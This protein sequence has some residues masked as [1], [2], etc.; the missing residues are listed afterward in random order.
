MRK[1]DIKTKIVR[2]LP[3]FIIYI[4]ILGLFSIN[5]YY[6]NTYPEYFISNPKS[7]YEGVPYI[8]SCS[9]TFNY[10]QSNNIVKIDND[11][12]TFVVGNEFYI[13]QANPIIYYVL[14]YEYLFVLLLI[15]YYIFT[16]KT[17]LLTQLNK[18]K[19]RDNRE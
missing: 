18:L 11:Y 13:K 16:E 7:N 12:C 19:E 17:F 6:N 2:L 4:A 15:L 9:S 3:A 10:N 14:K 8:I 1:K 5:L